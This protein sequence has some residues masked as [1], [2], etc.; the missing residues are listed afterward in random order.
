MSCLFS[1]VLRWTS[2]LAMSLRCG[3]TEWITSRSLRGES[4]PHWPCS[5]CCHQITGEPAAIRKARPKLCCVYIPRLINSQSRLKAETPRH[6]L[7]NKKGRRWLTQTVWKDRQ[8]RPS[9]NNS[10][11]S[12]RWP[13]LEFLFSFKTQRGGFV[14]WALNPSD[15]EFLFIHVWSCGVCCC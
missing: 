13:C 10:R 9:D 3:W 2:C 11:L 5:P 14:C 4:S 1:A 6:S 15:R 7:K 12:W 8:K